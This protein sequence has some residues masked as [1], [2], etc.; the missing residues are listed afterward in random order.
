MARLNLSTTYLPFELQPQHTIPPTGRGEPWGSRHSVIGAVQNPRQDHSIIAAPPHCPRG[1]GGPPCRRLP[2]L[3]KRGGGPP[4]RPRP[5]I[6]M[7]CQI[8]ISLG[9]A[10]VRHSHD[11]LLLRIHRVY[12]S[13]GSLFLVPNSL[14]VPLLGPSYTHYIAAVLAAATLLSSQHVSC[15]GWSAGL[16]GP[17]RRSPPVL[18]RRQQQLVGGTRR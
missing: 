12:E 16:C 15:L 2:D 17:R 10:L 13:P 9:P 18:G 5:L 11:T 7:G 3:H 6:T 4:T 14:S 8:L 1:T